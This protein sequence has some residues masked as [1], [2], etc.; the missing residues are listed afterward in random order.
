MRC[1]QPLICLTDDAAACRLRS[2]HRER[3]LILMKSTENKTK[4]MMDPG[5]LETAESVFQ[6][7]GRGLMEVSEMMVRRLCAALNE[8]RGRLM[9][10]GRKSFEDRRK[11]NDALEAPPGEQRR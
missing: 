4:L 3:R 5:G 1:V 2:P 9:L 8:E 6:A 7:L 10:R 11:K